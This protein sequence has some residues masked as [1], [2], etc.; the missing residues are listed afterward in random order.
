MNLPGV[1][2]ENMEVP[3]M[4]LPPTASFPEAQDLALPEMTTAFDKPE[5]Q[6]LPDVVSG[7][8]EAQDASLPGV[9]VEFAESKSVKLPTVANV[10]LASPSMGLP[11]KS[12]WGDKGFKL[13]DLGMVA[14]IGSAVNLAY[15]LFKKFTTKKDPEMNLPPMVDKYVIPEYLKPLFFFP[16]S[17][18]VNNADDTRRIAGGPPY[19]EAR[20]GM[21]GGASVDIMDVLPDTAFLFRAIGGD[22]RAENG[23]PF[24]AD[25]DNPSTHLNFDLCLTESHNFKGNLSTHPI[26]DGTSINDN[27]SEEGQENEVSMLVSDYSVNRVGDE[28]KKGQAQQIWQDLKAWFKERRLVAL[29]TT[30]ETYENV[31]ITA[32]HTERDGESGQALKIDITYKPVNNVK[33]KSGQISTVP[34]KPKST[35]SKKAQAQKN[36]GT[37]STSAPSTNT[38]PVDEQ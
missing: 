19:V 12:F 17:A 25:I 13:P 26:E 9:V 24:I 5:T 3:V 6:N 4:A 15:S 33:F 2:L 29:S 36:N 16:S 34:S 28:F 21:F 32:L 22:A 10:P 35:P 11:P 7:F 27:F 37:T 23:L 38:T 8:P 20:I 30:V 31:I 18:D 1:V 14:V